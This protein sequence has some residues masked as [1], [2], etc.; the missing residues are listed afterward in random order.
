MILRISSLS[1]TDTSTPEQT[2]CATTAAVVSITTA[3]F[4]GCVSVVIHIAICVYQCKS[5]KTKKG[6]A[7]RNSTGDYDAA[8]IEVVYEEV[9]DKKEGGEVIRMERNQAYSQPPWMK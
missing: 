5:R 6:Q 2:S 8:K 1:H 7:N 3:V 4:V 9:P